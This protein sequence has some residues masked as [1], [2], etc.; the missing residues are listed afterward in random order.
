MSAA[1]SRPTGGPPRWRQVLW[2]R[3]G[4]LTLGLFLLEFLA[5]A[6]TLVVMAAMPAVLHTL[7][8]VQLYGWAFSAPGLAMLAA[9][10]LAGRAADRAG[11][12]RPLGA[13]L[14]VFVLGNLVSA[15][16]PT[17]WAFV[18]G[19]FLQG[20]GA[21]AQ[22]AVSLGTVATAYPEDL[23]A[24]VLA[25]FAAAWI[26][27]GLVG[28]S[29]GALLAS[30]VGWRWA[31]V[32][33][34]P[35]AALAAAL[36][37]P[38]L[39]RSRMGAARPRKARE[40]APRRAVAIGW[41][42]LLAAGGALLL[43]GLTTVRTWGA[44]AAVAGLG[45]GVP[46]LRRIV[47][48]RGALPRPGLGAALLAGALLT[49]A[50]FA[51]DGFLPL[52]LTALRGRSLGEASLVVTLPTLGWAAGSWWQSRHAGTAGEGGHAALVRGG[53]AV[54][55]LGIVGVGVA[56]FPGG[57]LGVAYTA[58][59]LAGVGMGVAYPT[60]YLATMER[61]GGGDEASTVSLMAMADS[62]GTSVGAGLGGSAI[63]LAQ[64]LGAGLRAGLAGALGLALAAAL[65]LLVAAGRLRGPVPEAVAGTDPGPVR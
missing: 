32:A 22:Y 7:G 54:I 26:L 9:I 43:A 31:F 38:E 19:R 23:R 11:P 40:A 25:L 24:R 50:F 28:P 37:L 1:A 33:P 58:W 48:P 55:T 4:R 39:R 46:A 16:A 21:G 10:P 20:V 27:P 51:A 56:L 30:T 17:M 3:L 8:H 35:L 13:M 29:A 45:L 41:P 5:A 59:G 6:Q 52:L 57:P 15:G 64:G 62:L 49:F 2:G 60:V 34:L 18:A 65:A 36:T 63:A 14:A 44:A 42:L 53:T 47:R 12:A 61:A